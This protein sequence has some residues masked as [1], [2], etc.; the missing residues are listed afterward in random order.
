MRRST[1]YSPN[2]ALLQPKVATTTTTTEACDYKQMYFNY[3]CLQYFTLDF[4]AVLGHMLH[5]LH[6]WRISRLLVANRR[7]RVR[8]VRT[9]AAAPRIVRF[10]FVRTASTPLP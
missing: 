4:R 6:L 9:Y 7:R 5:M 8:L 2:A 1:R 10:A 3:L